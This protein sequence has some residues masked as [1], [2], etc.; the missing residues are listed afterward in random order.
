MEEKTLSEKESLQLITGM[1]SQ[2]KNYYYES[3]LGALLWGFTNL[4]CF[5][6]MYS[7]ETFSWFKFPFNPFYL[8]IITFLLQF[9][10]D[11]KERKYKQTVTFKNE[12]CKY[13]WLTF[14]ISVLI[15]TIAGALANIGYI[16]LPL[17]LLLFG[18]PTFLT[19]CITKF[20]P[21]IIGGIA[22]WIFCIIAFLYKGNITY[23]LVAMGA[24]IAWIIPG[25]ILRT[26]FSKN[27]AKREYG[28]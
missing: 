6:L 5:V 1:I 15:L 24:G 3:G 26:R 12:A 17:L 8:M 28:V 20:K 10:F 19:G 27:I 13:I 7:M 25:F 4:I 21:F 16:V 22:C 9:Y 18:I 14:G 2:A 11:R 23:L